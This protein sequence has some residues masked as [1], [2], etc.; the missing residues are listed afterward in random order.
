MNGGFGNECEGQIP[1]EEDTSKEY[2]PS[3]SRG[4][5]EMQKIRKE[6]GLR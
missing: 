5:V 4:T 6:E 3:C 2:Y 1:A